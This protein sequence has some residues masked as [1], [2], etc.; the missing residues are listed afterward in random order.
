M[1]G[2]YSHG[3][4]GASLSASYTLSPAV[5]LTA[6]ATA[7]RQVRNALG[8]GSGNGREDS[9]RLAVSFTRLPL[10]LPGVVSL[11]YTQARAYVGYFGQ[12]LGAQY[13]RTHELGLTYSRAF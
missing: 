3:L 13:Q 10:D 5:L 6:S 1:G 7:G 9:G 12:A 4:I 11:D 8:N 2:S